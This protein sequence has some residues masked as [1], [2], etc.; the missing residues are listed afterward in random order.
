MES[1]IEEYKRF[2]LESDP[3]PKHIRIQ[4]EFM[5]QYMFHSDGWFMLYAKDA[6]LE[7]GRLKLVEGE[8]KYSVTEMLFVK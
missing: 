7:S 8:Q 5:L 3:M 2:V 1:E 6:L 4:Q